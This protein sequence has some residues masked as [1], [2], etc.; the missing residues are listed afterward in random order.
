M[1]N[2]IH[3]KPQH[4]INAILVFFVVHTTQIGVGIHGFQRI[5]YQESKQDAWI[6]VL[7]IGLASHVVAIV[8]IKTLEMYDSHDLYGINREVFGAWMGNF[9]NVIYVFYCSVAFFSVLRNYIEVVQTWIFPL[10]STWFISATLLLL[11]I[12][13]FLGGLRV[14]V[15]VAFFSFILAFWLIFVLV[16]PLQYSDPQ[17]LFPILES[18]FIDILKGAK[19]MTFT[20]IGFEILYIIFPFVNEKKKIAK[21]VHYGLLL[22]TLM[23]LA[24]I[25]VTLTYFSGEQLSKTIWATLSLFSIVQLP[26][27][28]R[29][30]FLAV[31][32]WM[33]IILPNLCLYVWAAHRGLKSMIEI[34]AKKFIWVFSIIVLLL[35]IFIKSRIQINAVNNIFA[36]VAFYVVF[37]YPLVLY[38]LALVKKK[39][40]SQRGVT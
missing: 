16:F 38:V 23:Y 10:L 2:V 21:P 20:I 37:I 3:V 9:I 40:T 19:A 34:S 12:Y 27:L 18:E 7:V 26:F 29:F 39:L 32:F 35:T 1:K 28:E 15:G 36:Q 13:T 33:L 24:V 6:S 5:I 30:E 14:I 25:L 31:C 4:M 11:V 8:M 17:S 22:T